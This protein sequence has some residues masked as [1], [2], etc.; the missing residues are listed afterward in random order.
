MS[1]CYRFYAIPSSIT[2]IETPNIKNGNLF[3]NKKNT[4]K[5]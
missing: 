4:I 3:V 2:Y 5:E 1:F